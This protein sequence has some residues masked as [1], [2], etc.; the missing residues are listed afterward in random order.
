LV[1]ERPYTGNI[2]T[3]RNIELALM[4]LCTSCQY[5]NWCRIKPKNCWDRIQGGEVRMDKKGIV[6]VVGHYVNTSDCKFTGLENRLP[7]E[8]HRYLELL[9][10]IHSG[11]LC[12]QIGDKPIIDIIR[13]VLEEDS[14]NTAGKM[15]YEIEL[16]AQF[17]LALKKVLTEMKD[18][19]TEERA[20]VE[21][22]KSQF[23]EILNETKRNS[24]RIKVS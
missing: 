5:T 6:H 19:A 12:F 14:R 2:A 10:E 20:S 3:R 11:S 21:A 17:K 22:V 8:T 4:S 15:L 13:E 9:N 24:E 23:I 16:C 18:T 7:R 1:S